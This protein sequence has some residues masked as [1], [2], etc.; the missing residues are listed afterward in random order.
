[1]DSWSHASLSNE[2]ASQCVS[3]GRAD[4]PQQKDRPA[5]IVPR[6]ACAQSAAPSPTHKRCGWKRCT[7]NRGDSSLERV[8][9]E[10]W[11]QAGVSAIRAF[12]MT[13]PQTDRL[14]AWLH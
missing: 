7:N 8:P 11:A 10:E 12:S 14:Q 3:A 2:K 6:D 5:K 13:A 1:M 9:G 4:T